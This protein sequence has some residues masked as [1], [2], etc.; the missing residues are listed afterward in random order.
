[1]KTT[2]ATTSTQSASAPKPTSASPLPYRRRTVDLGVSPHRVFSELAKNKAQLTGE[3]KD[4]L[5]RQLHEN[6][7]VS[8]HRDNARAIAKRVN[9]YIHN[10]SEVIEA[11]T[12][13]QSA[14]ASLA[15]G[16]ES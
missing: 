7:S 2:N 6:L 15:A 4:T 11:A 10:M 13:L 9:S 16:P 12:T 1:M 3:P 8:L 14:A 5:L